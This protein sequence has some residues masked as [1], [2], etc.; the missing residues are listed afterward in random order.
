MA[1]IKY[2]ALVSE[3]RNKLN[4]SVLSKNRYGN[5]M[6]NKVTP[7]NPQTSFQ[8]ASRQLLASLSQGWAG[9][10]DAQRQAWRDFAKTV[11]FT[12]IFGD[13]K[14]LD[15]KAMY[16]KCNANLTNVGEATI[17]TPGQPTGFAP[18]SIIDSVM[19]EGSGEL[20]TANAEIDTS[21]TNADFG[22]LIS[23]TPNLKASINF[24]KNQFRLVDG[25]TD[26]VEASIPFQDIWNARFGGATQGD[27]I[28]FKLQFVDLAT[29]LSSVPQDQGVVVTASP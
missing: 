1:K 6:R 19:G 23:M 4:G 17:S 21:M 26:W 28:W 24:V 2:S 16:V 20:V 11:P 25:N 10:T 18:V 12:D 7:V 5:Y 29:G 3:M 14:F 9:L 8:T 27:K 22:I 13:Q 15:G